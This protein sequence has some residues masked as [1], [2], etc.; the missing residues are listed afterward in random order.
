MLLAGKEILSQSLFDSVSESVMV[1][2]KEI[3]EIVVIINEQLGP[4]L[5]NANATEL[6]VPAPLSAYQVKK[7]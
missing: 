4:L 3:P 7:G 6:P 5:E 2:A 1:S